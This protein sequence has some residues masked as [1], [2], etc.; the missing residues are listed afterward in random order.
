[1]PTLGQVCASMYS[2]PHVESMDLNWIGCVYSSQCLVRTKCR[3]HPMHRDGRKSFIFLMDF[4]V[5]Q[6]LEVLKAVFGTFVQNLY[7][8][9]KL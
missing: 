6:K 1:M 3:G 9:Y 7:S 4:G 5:F 8:N 2:L